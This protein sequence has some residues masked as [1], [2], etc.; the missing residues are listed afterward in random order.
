MHVRRQRERFL[1]NLYKYN[2]YF[3]IYMFIKNRIKMNVYY[4]G[5]KKQRGEIFRNLF[6]VLLRLWMKEKF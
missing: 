6:W 5:Y 4:K 2:I 1:K 3:L